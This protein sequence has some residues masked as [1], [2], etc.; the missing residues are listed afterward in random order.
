MLKLCQEGDAALILHHM[1]QQ[2][3]LYITSHSCMICT[4]L[5]LQQGLCHAHP[6]ILQMIYIFIISL[7]VLL[8]PSLD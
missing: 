3:A 8:L 6:Y 7:S 5:S 1:S 2:I 4:A